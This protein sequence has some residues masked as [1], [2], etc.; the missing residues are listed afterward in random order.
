[1]KAFI[2]FVNDHLLFAIFMF[3]MSITA[4]TLVIWRLLLNLNARTNM[5]QFLPELQET[6][7]RSGTGAATDSQDASVEVVGSS[8]GQVVSRD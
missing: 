5:T 6:L 1:M 8:V 2:T 7:D 3:A 4:A